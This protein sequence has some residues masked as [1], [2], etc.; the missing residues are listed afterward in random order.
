MRHDV[1]VRTLSAE[2]VQLFPRLPEDAITSVTLLP[3]SEDLFLQSNKP[4]A[5]AAA[6][7]G[8]TMPRSTVFGSISPMWGCIA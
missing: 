1:R 7:S 6:S 2:D 4:A 3:I 5:P 8:T